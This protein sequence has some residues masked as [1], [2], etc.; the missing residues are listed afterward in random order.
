M[1]PSCWHNCLQRS[2]Q[3]FSNSNWLWRSVDV[4]FL[5]VTLCVFRVGRRTVGHG[6]G[7]VAALPVHPRWRPE[8]S[9]SPLTVCRRPIQSV[10]GVV[11]TKHCIISRLTIC[12]TQ[13]G[14]WDVGNGPKCRFPRPSNY[15]H[16]INSTSGLGTAPQTEP[17]S[18]PVHEVQRFRHSAIVFAHFHGISYFLRPKWRLK[19]LPVTILTWIFDF[20]HPVSS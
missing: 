3:F 15:F 5:F 10:D 8:V 16:W 17:W 2:E 14:T 13:V 4:I 6:P 9:L 19:L 18:M 12:G 20:L 7:A 1:G 11:A